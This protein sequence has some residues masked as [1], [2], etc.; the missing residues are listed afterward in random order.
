MSNKRKKRGG[1]GKLVFGIPG[2]L[3]T[4]QAFSDGTSKR[5]SSNRTPSS[6]KNADPQGGIR[7]PN[8]EQAVDRLPSVP[9]SLKNHI[10]LDQRARG[11]SATLTG[12][13]LLTVVFVDDPTSAWSNE[14]IK[15]ARSEL[16]ATFDAIMA[17]AAVYGVKLNLAMA[18]RRASVGIA[19]DRNNLAPWVNS[20]LASAGLKTLKDASSALERRYGFKEAPVLFYVNTDDRA[21]AAPSVYGET[22]FALFCNVE[23]AAAQYR[24]EIYHIFGAKDYYYPSDLRAVAQKYYPN[25]TMLYAESPVT[26]PLTAYLI[27]WTDT[28]TQNALAFLRE[29]AYLTPAYIEEQLKKETYTG[30]VRNRRECE[31]VYTGYL[32]FGVKQG[33]GKMVFDNGVIYEGNWESGQLW[34]RATA[35][36]PEGVMYQGD[37][38]NGNINGKGTYYFADGTIYAGEFQN[39]MFHGRG[40]LTYP[41]GKVLSGIWDKGKFVG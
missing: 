36:W 6:A 16:S 12:N 29:T 35:R 31:G 38:E 10:L 8:G 7:P 25:S 14:E 26:D 40:T 4:G 1:F 13:V 17:D 19:M 3:L 20:A 5:Y 27:G 41:D 9:D 34:G 11:I 23:N 24:H 30:Y 2:M 15:R 28:L 33:Q 32:K 37:W 22:E 39:G 21:F 18:C